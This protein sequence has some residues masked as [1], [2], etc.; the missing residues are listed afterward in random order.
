MDKVAIILVNYNGYKDSFDCIESINKINYK[1]YEII[2]VDNGSTDDSLKKLK[3]IENDKLVLI[4]AQ[5][6]L[7][8]AGANNLGI[9]YALENGSEFVLLLNNDT[10]VNFD[11]L[12]NLVNCYKNSEKNTV[13]TPKIMYADKKNVIWFGGGTFSKL[14]GRTTHTGINEIDKAQCDI[15]KNITFMS[16]CCML[17]SKDTIID[18]GLM[19]SDYFLYCEDLDYCCRLR[20]GGYYLKYC[21][22]SIIFHKVNASTNKVTGIKTYY[23]VRNKR[24]IINKYISMPFRILA[25][26]Y[27]WL[28][29]SKRICTGEYVRSV[30]KRAKTDFKKSIVGKIKS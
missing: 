21:P 3:E 20:K 15:E 2:I 30:V 28:E 25:N 23:S 16:G 11:F 14:S 17:I 4:N 8:F 22:S 7:G 19:D 29:E 10:L 6:N 9:K 5:R 13:V 12:S 26:L 18:V 27:N 24:Y 1:D